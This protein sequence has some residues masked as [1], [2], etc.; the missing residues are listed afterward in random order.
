MAAKRTTKRCACAKKPKAAKRTT[1]KLYVWEWIGG[2]H[3][4]CHASSPAEALR[5]A[6]AMANGTTL[7]VD[8][9]TLRAASAATQARLS[10]QYFD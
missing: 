5:K 10:R 3:N 8:R 6:N 9:K 2:G 1:S 7:K 4:D